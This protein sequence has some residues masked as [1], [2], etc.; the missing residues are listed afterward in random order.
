LPM[1]RGTPTGISAVIDAYGR[2]LPNR[3]LGQGEYGVIDSLLPPALPVTPFEA[4][5]EAAFALMMLASFAEILFRVAA[6]LRR[7]S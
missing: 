2:V 1:V 5:G 4:W 7:K 6:T 3:Q